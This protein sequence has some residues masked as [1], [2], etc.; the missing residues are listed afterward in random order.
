M[1]IA[2]KF[3]ELITSRLPNYNDQLNSGCSEEKIAHLE[4]IIEKTLPE[5]YKSILLFCN[6][7]KLYPSIMASYMLPIEEIIPAYNFIV[8]KT[9][10]TDEELVVTQP[11]LAQL[12]K[13]GLK[14]VP[15]AESGSANYLCFDYAP[16]Q[17]GK[18][19]QIT[20]IALGEP[21]AITV[22]ADSFDDF[23]RLL[24]RA[25]E[26]GMISFEREYNSDK[27]HFIH[28]WIWYAGWAKSKARHFNPKLQY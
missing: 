22:V 1:D 21:D 19:G 3:I 11:T 12:Q 26:T 8:N 4:S 10:N 17:N 23:L 5:S 24:L 2:A 15:F 27:G 9:D 7:E 14:R 16:A 28:D 20:Y 18:E 6:G 13:Y 25:H